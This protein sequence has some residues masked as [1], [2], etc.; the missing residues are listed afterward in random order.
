MDFSFSETKTDLI[1]LA[2]QIFDRELTLEGRK[3]AELN[4]SFLADTWHSVAESGLAG[5]TVAERHG[6]L[7]LSF[8]DA[9][10]V[11]VDWLFTASLELLF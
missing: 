6:G 9:A 3:A 4:N 11:L 7:G 2:R 8:L 10:V 5:I 1:G